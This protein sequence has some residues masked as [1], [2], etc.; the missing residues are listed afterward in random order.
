[1]MGVLCAAPIDGRARVQLL[2]LTSE[3]DLL[4]D[5]AWTHEPRAVILR[6][7]VVEINEEINQKIKTIIVV[8]HGAKQAF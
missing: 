5:G 6:Q 3:T 7:R 8:P 2:E 1:M 4:I